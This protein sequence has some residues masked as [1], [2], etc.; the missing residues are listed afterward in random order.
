MDELSRVIADIM[1]KNGDEDTERRE[2]PPA[3]TPQ[4]GDDPIMGLLN[5]FSQQNG[6]RMELLTALKPHV[7][8]ERCRKIDKICGIVRTAY[9]IRGALSSLGGLM[10]V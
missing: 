3:E 10:N 4:E 5:G 9:M 1:S 8:D 2:N 7:C 6:Q